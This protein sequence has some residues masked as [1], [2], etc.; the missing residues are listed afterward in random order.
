VDPQ[1]A[2]DCP[3]CGSPNACAV[4]ESGRFDT[5]CWCTAAAFPAA[6][7]AALPEADR[8]RACVCA[9]CAAAAASDPA[10]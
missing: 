9:G 10:S 8:G 7:L 2:P 4:A 1:N 6:L 3:L 5:A